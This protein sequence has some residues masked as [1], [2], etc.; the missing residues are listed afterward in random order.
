MAIIPALL[1]RMSSRSV[2][3]F[4]TSAASLTDARED[5][6][7]GSITML[8]FGTDALILL[9]EASAFSLDRD[10]R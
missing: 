5:K 4:R 6:S 8:A 2:V 9:I 7:K 1:M 3:V 10:A